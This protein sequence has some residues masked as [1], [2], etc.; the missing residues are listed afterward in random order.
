MSRRT[1]RI[2]Q[3]E[4]VAEAQTFTRIVGLYRADGCCT[5][6]S[7]QLAYGHQ[8][9]FGALEHQPCEVCAPIVA[10]F[11]KPQLCGWRSVQ[12]AGA[13]ARNHATLRRSTASAAA[14][15][16]P[17]RGA[18]R[19]RPRTRTTGCSP[20]CVQPTPK[21]RLQ[22]CTLCHR[23]FSG[24]E[25]GDRHRIGSHGVSEGPGRRHCRTD[26]ELIKAGL[27][28]D[29]RGVWRLARSFD[30]A[31]DVFHPTSNPE[32]GAADP[33]GAAAQPPCSQRMSSGSDLFRGE[34]DGGC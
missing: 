21:T 7:A 32:K 15:A 18:A 20:D 27:R 9:G 16:I 22:H 4:T 13:D 29:G 5:R 8:L 19:E 1:R 6:C 24:T 3:P 12:G 31:A 11:P 28:L 26:G 34:T 25:S 33:P 10:G 17:G 30:D 14:E 2:D 23:T